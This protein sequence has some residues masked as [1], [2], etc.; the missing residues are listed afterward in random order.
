[1]G[2]HKKTLR[3]KLQD[4]FKEIAA[5]KPK[6]RAANLEAFAAGRAA[7]ASPAL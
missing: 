4:N 6:Y 7:V 2:R 3:R 5:V 1:M